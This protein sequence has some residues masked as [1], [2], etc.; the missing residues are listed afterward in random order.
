MATGK[1]VTLTIRFE[2]GPKEAM[3]TGAKREHCSI[4]DMVEVVIRDYCGRQGI[5]I[6][7]QPALFPEEDRK[8]QPPER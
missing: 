4:A 7:E 1:T 8:S 3:R 2:P 6:R 5:T